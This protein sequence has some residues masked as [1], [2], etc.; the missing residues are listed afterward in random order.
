M[1]S[2]FEEMDGLFVFIK[3]APFQQICFELAPNFLIWCCLHCNF[4][5]LKEGAKHIERGLSGN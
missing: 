1:K 4:I 3:N 2:L 5:L